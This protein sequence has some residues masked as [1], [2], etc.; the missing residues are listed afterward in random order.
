MNIL[1][2]HSNYP[3]QFKYLCQA[4]AADSRHEVVF[5]TGRE[6]DQSEYYSGLKIRTF[7]QHRTPAQNTH[8][9]LSATEQTILIGQAVIR[10]VD[11]LLKSGF[12]PDLIFAHAGNG[13]SLFIKDILPSAKLIGYFEWFFRPETSCYLFPSFSIDDQLKVGVR[14]FPILREL[15]IC[16]VAVTPTAWQKQQFPQEFHSKLK[17]IFDGIDNNFF[18]PLNADQELEHRSCDHIIRNRDNNESFVLK[19]DSIVLSYATRGMEPLRGFPEF[20]KALPYVLKSNPELNVFIAGADRRAYSYDAPTENGSWKEYLMNELGDFNGKE[21][22]F[23]TGLLNYPDY[24]SLLWR[25]DLHCYFTRPYVT[26]W[27]FFEACACGTKLMSNHSPATT[28]LENS[29]GINFINLDSSP[30]HLSSEIINCILDKSGPK[31]RLSNFY[32]LAESMKS[33]QKLIS[34]LMD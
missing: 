3:A 25:T 19:K 6:V 14:N 13:L 9:Y 16:D 31:S 23:F 26:S 20:I 8:H 1:F 28:L 22:I 29:D 4:L 32:S 21:R 5:L 33:W 17:V 24:R 15:E 30:E 18:Y 10:E 2:I 11:E 7:N 27:S 34:E 12:V